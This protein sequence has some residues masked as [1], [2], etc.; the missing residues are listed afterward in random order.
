MWITIRLWWYIAICYKHISKTFSNNFYEDWDVMSWSGYVWPR[1]LIIKNNNNNANIIMTPPKSTWSVV[2]RIISSHII[3]WY[4]AYITPS[5]CI[6]AKC[7]FHG[8]MWPIFVV[9]ALM[10][11]SMVSWLDMCHLQKYYI[12]CVRMTLQK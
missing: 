8:A 1:K 3:Q 4:N 7:R 9:T 2:R 6:L 12:D 10:F 5:I 11:P